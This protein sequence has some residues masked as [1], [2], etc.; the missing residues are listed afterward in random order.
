MAVLN[1]STYCRSDRQGV[2]H[3]ENGY[4]VV[5]NINNP[6]RIEVYDTQDRLLARYDVP[7][8]ISGYEYEF[9][10]AVRCI[11]AGKTESDSMPM[12]RTVQVMEIMDS[13]RKQWGVVYPQE[14]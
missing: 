2:L 14:Q 3:G 11:G 13:L 4:I 7:Q 1:H 12:E 8:Q 5:S 9:Q 10:E 6:Q